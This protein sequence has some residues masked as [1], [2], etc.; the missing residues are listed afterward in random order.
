MLSLYELN[1]RSN[2]LILSCLNHSSSTGG[3]AFGMN[4]AKVQ[5]YCKVPFA[6]GPVFISPLTRRSYRSA[7][8][9][10]APGKRRKPAL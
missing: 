9:L 3:T 4:Y 2:A 5:R 10:Q 1:A 7:D 6:W 8:R